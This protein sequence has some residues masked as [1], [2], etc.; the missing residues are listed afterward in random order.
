MGSVGPQGPAKDVMEIVDIFEL[1]FSKE[2]IDTIVRETNRYTEQFL[3]GREL[4]VRSPARAWKPVR[5]GEIY[6]V[7]GV[8][9][10]GHYPET[11][12]KVIFY[13]QKS[14]FHTGI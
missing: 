2:L 10:Y 1:F 9:A 5:E 7:Q 4:S 6:I 12:S 14:D 13:H 8:H 11:Y 3:C